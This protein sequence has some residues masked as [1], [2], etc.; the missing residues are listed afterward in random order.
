MLRNFNQVHIVMSS[1]MSMDEDEQ[2]F[3]PKATDPPSMWLW[4]NQ[5][6]KTLAA[7]YWHNG[8]LLFAEVDNTRDRTPKR[9][10]PSG[11]GF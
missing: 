5:S 1:A 7:I 10:K 8:Q 6:E 11:G 3:R 9:A 2:R 4:L